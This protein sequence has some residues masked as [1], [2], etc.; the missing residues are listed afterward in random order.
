MLLLGGKLKNVMEDYIEIFFYILFTLIFIIVGSLG[1][2]KK[3]PQ[4]AGKTQQNLYSQTTQSFKQPLNIF[5]Y[6]EQQLKESTSNLIE[7][8]QEPPAEDE[9]IL[10]VAPVEMI[11]NVEQQIKTKPK[12]SENKNEEDEQFYFDLRKAVIYSAILNRKSY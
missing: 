1:K 9:P 10:D 11:E 5:D 7:D 8:N 4:A 3:K 12:V 2:K 6:L